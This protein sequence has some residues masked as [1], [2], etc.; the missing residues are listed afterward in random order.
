MI[1]Y[2]NMITILDHLADIL[3]K[4][5]NQKELEYHIFWNHQS[6]TFHSIFD[7]TSEI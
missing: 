2:L 6:G 1:I 3:D 4:H 5:I 7:V